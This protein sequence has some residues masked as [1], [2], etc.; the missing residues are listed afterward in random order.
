[1][2]GGKSCTAYDV[3]VNPKFL[4]KTEVNIDTTKHL[5][6]QILQED[7]VFHSFFMTVILDGLEQKYELTLDRSTAQ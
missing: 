7:D 4:K 6:E 1:M 5:T 2:E 3:V